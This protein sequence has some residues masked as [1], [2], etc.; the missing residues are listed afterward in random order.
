MLRKGGG[1]EV[2]S[3]EKGLERFLVTRG[4]T[5]RVWCQYDKCGAREGE[6]RGAC[7]ELEEA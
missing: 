2:E 1:T 6:I 7:I 4:R 5:S 3:K